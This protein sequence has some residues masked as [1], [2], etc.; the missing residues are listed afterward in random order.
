MHDLVGSWR[1][2]IFDVFIL[3]IWLH[4]I[5]AIML[6]MLPASTEYGTSHLLMEK[7]L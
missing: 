5:V 3:Y 6:L 2:Y 4:V 1:R 7:G